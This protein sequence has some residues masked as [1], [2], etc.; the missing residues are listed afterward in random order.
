MKSQLPGG[1]AASCRY[2]VMDRPE[3]SFSLGLHPEPLPPP[4]TGRSR[5]TEASS[6]PRWARD[7][8]TEGQSRWDP[9]FSKRSSEAVFF[10][11]NLLPL[12][13][14][15]HKCSGTKV[16][17]PAAGVT[18]TH[19]GGSRDRMGLSPAVWTM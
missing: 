13:I 16:S 3:K 5:S 14:R 2:K 19:L 7:R 10:L 1:W 18:V 15:K 6:A 17:F 8:L 11:A 9:E 12:I 4:P